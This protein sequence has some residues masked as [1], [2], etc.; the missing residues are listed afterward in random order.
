MTPP[1]PVPL[2]GRLLL[3][4]YMARHRLTFHALGLRLGCQ[5]CVPSRWAKG[6]RVPSLRLGLLL[7][8]VTGGDIP[9]RSWSSPS[10]ARPALPY[11]RAG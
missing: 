5:G 11:R 1:D 7:E 10:D 8:D 2:P 3:R 4:S 9:A 6:D